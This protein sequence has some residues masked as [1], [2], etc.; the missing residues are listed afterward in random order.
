MD[1]NETF[2]LHIDFA[3]VQIALNYISKLNL[4][5]SKKSNLLWSFCI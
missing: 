5:K 1:E 4:V 3:F 2:E